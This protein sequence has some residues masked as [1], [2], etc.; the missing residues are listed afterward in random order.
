MEQLEHLLLDSNLDYLCL[1]E[2]W[3]TSTTPS[4]VF[5]IPGYNVYRWDGGKGKGGGVLIYVRDS[6]DSHQIDIPVQIL[7]CVG[8]IITLSAQ[9][10]FILLAVYRPRNATNEFYFDLAE[11]HKKY[12]TKETLVMGD[13]N[14]LA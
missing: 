13:L 6:I 14:I 7:D 9:M 1:T 5:T 2:T 10:S 12:E 11:I 3:L 4:S 8:V